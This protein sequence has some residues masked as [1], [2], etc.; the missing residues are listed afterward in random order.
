MSNSTLSPLSDDVVPNDDLNYSARPSF[1][2]SQNMQESSFAL[3]FMSMD[4]G[5][6]LSPTLNI[7]SPHYDLHSPTESHNSSLMTAFPSSPV[8]P[9]MNFLS[10]HTSKDNSYP[11]Q[12]KHSPQ[13]EMLS[14]DAE[15]Q[16]PLTSCFSLTEAFGLSRNLSC[17]PP[18]PSKGNAIPLP[19]PPPPVPQTKTI[20]QA[21]HDVSDSAPRTPN[22]IQVSQVIPNNQQ[23]IPL[24]SK[25]M[26]FIPL[27]SAREGSIETTPQ[28]PN[29]FSES[30]ICITSQS[31]GAL[32]SNAGGLP[33]PPYQFILPPSFAALNQKRLA[34]ASGAPHLTQNN[35]SRAQPFII[36]QNPSSHQ[37]IQN[38]QMQ[39]SS[40]QISTTP[41][42]AQEYADD[43]SM[44]TFA[45]LDP[46]ASA[47]PQSYLPPAPTNNFQS[48][49]QTS[50]SPRLNVR[51]RKSES[52]NPYLSSMA[53]QQ[54]SLTQVSSTTP[55]FYPNTPPGISLNAP[56]AYQHG[57][58]TSLQFDS[59]VQGHI[60]IHP[61]SSQSPQ[62]ISSPNLS[63]SCLTPPSP[64][65]Q[66]SLQIRGRLG[67]RRQFH[68]LRSEKDVDG[69]A[70]FRSFLSV[71]GQV[72]HLLTTQ[73]GNRFLQ[74]VLDVLSAQ[75]HPP[76][77]DDED[78]LIQARMFDLLK[79]CEDFRRERKKM[80]EKGEKEWAERERNRIKNLKQIGFGSITT[81]SVSE[82]AQWGERNDIQMGQSKND[83]P[84][85]QLQGGGASNGILPH[86]SPANS[87]SSLSHTPTQRSMTNLSHKP[88]LPLD[89]S[90]LVVYV[91]DVVIKEVG[92]DLRMLC[93]NQF[94]NYTVQ[95][96]MM[97]GNTAQR[98]EIFKT[99]CMDVGWMGCHPFASRV[100]QRMVDVADSEEQVSMLR[101]QTEGQVLQMI[102]HASGV[103]LL[104]KFITTWVDDKNDDEWD[105]LLDGGEN[106]CQAGKEKDRKT[107][108]HI[109]EKEENHAPGYLR[110]SLFVLDELLTREALSHL[111]STRDGCTL[112]QKL[113][114]TA[115]SEMREKIMRKE[116][117]VK[118]YEAKHSIYMAEMSQ[119]GITLLHPSYPPSHLVRPPSS[120][121]ALVVRLSEEFHLVTALL[122][123]EERTN[124]FIQSL[125]MLNWTAI[126]AWSE[127]KHRQEKYRAKFRNNSPSVITTPPSQSE[128]KQKSCNKCSESPVKLNTQNSSPKN[129]ASS[130]CIVANRHMLPPP[131]PPPP[132]SLTVLHPLASLSPASFT[133]QV[134]SPAHTQLPPPPLYADD[135]T[136]H[137]SPPTASPYL[138]TS[139]SAPV[140][141]PSAAS[142][143]EL[144]QSDA[145]SSISCMHSCS[146]PHSSIHIPYTLPSLR[147]MFFASFLPHFAELCCSKTAS[148]TIERMI[149]MCDWDTKKELV[150]ILLQPSHQ[151]DNKGDNAKVLFNANKS[152]SAAHVTPVDS[153]PVTSSLTSSS[154]TP[155]SSSVASFG[156][157]T[158]TDLCSS[159][160]SDS[161]Q[162]GP[163]R[164]SKLFPQKQNTQPINECVSSLPPLPSDSLSLPAL[165]SSPLSLCAS[166]ATTNSTTTPTT[167]ITPPTA[168]AAEATPSSATAS[169][170]HQMESTSSLLCMHTLSVYSSSSSTPLLIQL[171]L[172][173]YASSVVLRLLLSLSLPDL[174]PFFPE[175]IAATEE[176]RANRRIAL[177]QSKAN[178]LSVAQ[179]KTNKF[180]EKGACN[181]EAK[182]E[183]K[184]VM[185]I[186]K[187][188]KEKSELDE[189]GEDHNCEEES[190]TETET[191]LFLNDSFDEQDLMETSDREER[192]VLSSVRSTIYQ[193][194]SPTSPFAKSFHSS[195]FSSASSAS[196][197]PRQSP[198]GSATGQS[199]GSSSVP[200]SGSNSASGSYSQPAPVS[201][202]LLFAPSNSPSFSP[203]FAPTS[204][205]LLRHSPSL[206]TD[207]LSPLEF[208]LLKKLERKKRRH[209]KDTKKNEDDGDALSKNKKDDETEEDTFE[210][211]LV[212]MR[213]IVEVLMDSSSIIR[214]SPT[215]MQVL[216]S[217]S[218]L[219]MKMEEHSA[220]R[221]SRLK[222]EKT[223]SEGKE[224]SGKREY[225]VHKDALFRR[226]G[227]RR[228]GADPSSL[229]YYS[230]RDGEMQSIERNMMVRTS[231]SSPSPVA[232]FSHYSTSSSLSPFFYSPSNSTVPQQSDSPPA[233]SA[234]AKNRSGKE[235]D[236][237]DSASNFKALG[238]TTPLPPLPS[239]CSA[240]ASA[241]SSE[242]KQNNSSH[243]VNKCAVP[244][245]SVLFPPSSIHTSI[246]NSNSNNCNNN[247]N[248]R[249]VSPVPEETEPTSLRY[250]KVARL[251]KQTNKKEAN[252]NSSSDSLA[253]RQKTVKVSLGSHTVAL[254]KKNIDKLES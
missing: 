233:R 131:P 185:H 129:P 170:K 47:V 188:S 55:P 26:Q 50:S 72:L 173:P 167:P 200:L 38:S 115:D 31:D 134:M 220:S 3:D 27:V 166:P 151:N 191:D 4:P 160:L 28:S 252:S 231:S 18:A 197:S 177:L 181:K 246:S 16:K 172:N 10:S 80:A 196:L 169:P 241:S 98:D 150:R 176:E 182:K 35:V 226:E 37:M 225:S 228:E 141:L 184:T 13:R 95:R 44:L 164:D 78:T 60:A 6:V 89:P 199:L 90:P 126:D 194:T 45:S 189:G 216:E 163:S 12:E 239:T 107:I 208:A 224:M 75:S 41:I 54:N 209:S 155:L 29:I 99:V 108:S 91:I 211:R 42:R 248:N 30:P 56:H 145:P 39:N 136:N 127:A 132:P 178:K 53:E 179:Q 171:S 237:T 130:T 219:L 101:R 159:F 222:R 206:L 232:S 146:R 49:M 62:N 218:M 64:Y 20:S 244:Q 79:K 217:G 119:R 168:A 165:A 63:A 240:P 195:S 43:S 251:Q 147:H 128:Q 175:N 207:P 180:K 88:R 104:T 249:N 138:S 48:P 68:A 135:G 1:L 247:N 157:S 161:A 186:G 21:N 114:V 61:S 153:I 24:P 77:K 84:S 238:S 140:T 234:S 236:K 120:L 58:S 9:V 122:L 15:V 109:V 22:V 106:I 212:M 81:G 154:S 33:R 158:Q 82:E 51:M 93:L 102:K 112:L 137:F 76:T 105:D 205:F 133:S 139:A 143:C 121:V 2:F 113:V 110:D 202:P 111:L 66:S 215:G 183:A 187:G 14:F 144:C 198:S 243:A 74:K 227:E 190:E 85:P 174:L 40:H 87:Y 17:S 46:S 230:P 59:L 229:Y 156:S 67:P 204:A 221:N 8:S 117:K 149:M 19:P 223:G 70:P 96:L 123:N 86:L 214:Y 36:M 94:G 103:H 124:T 235:A 11:E 23:T 73:D 125:T 69:K 34:A 210:A 245:Q 116:R 193:L 162:T 97:R 254:Q 32:A 192:A 65:S 203:S 83:S 118:E 148:P 92:N 250:R 253:P 52:A 57:H 213:S 201:P 100:I 71:T 152:L 7:C 5:I 242:A 25:T 142:R